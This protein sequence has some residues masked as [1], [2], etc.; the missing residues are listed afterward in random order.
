MRLAMHPSKTCFDPL[1]GEEVGHIT[2]HLRGVREARVNFLGQDHKLEGALDNLLQSLGIQAQMM[3]FSGMAPRPRRRFGF[4]YQ[5]SQ[6]IL[7]VEPRGKL[8][9]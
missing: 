8:R 3:R 9:V 5:G 1:S 7:F 4:R 6:A 2:R